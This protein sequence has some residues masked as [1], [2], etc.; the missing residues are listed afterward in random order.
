MNMIFNKRG[1]SCILAACILT[2]CGSANNESDFTENDDSGQTTANAS[3][4]VV[5]IEEE[6][7]ASEPNIN[8]LVSDGSPEK[9]LQMYIAAL[10]AEDESNSGKIAS[11]LRT[12]VSDFVVNLKLC[13]RDFGV[14]DNF[15]LTSDAW[16]AFV[17][18][19]A[20]VNSDLTG[21]YTCYI[22]V[23]P[24]KILEAIAAAEGTTV[25]E[26]C[27]KIGADE[28]ALYYNWGYDIDGKRYY[29]A[30][31]PFLEKY[32]S[33]HTASSSGTKTTVFPSSFTSE[34]LER[35]EDCLGTKVITLKK[36]GT[37]VSVDSL[38]SYRYQTS[39]T[40]EHIG[41]TDV[42]EEEERSRGFSY[43]GL[44]FDYYPTAAIKEID[45]V[46]IY[47]G[48]MPI[49]CT[50]FEGDMPFASVMAEYDE[51][52][53]NDF[54]HI[55]LDTLLVDTFKYDGI[56]SDDELHDT[57]SVLMLTSQS[58]YLCCDESDRIGVYT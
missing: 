28:E 4:A 38:K 34:Q 46:D 33:T 9:A 56:V 42:V 24:H 22:R 23:N 36:S 37:V 6:A 32:L 54:T 16:E 20:N 17:D 43:I 55:L 40:T 21:E 57:L 30:D 49:D 50:I 7:A 8:R 25:D 10:L 18:T 52:S 2:A 45:G 53:L 1:L 5:T 35:A 19:Q 48:Y 11:K 27:K 31:E 13:A 51:N 47:D 3:E 12:D 44:S 15:F 14:D 29:Y 41:H 26:V 58:P 39:I